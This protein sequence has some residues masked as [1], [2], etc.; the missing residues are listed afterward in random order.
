MYRTGRTTC[1]TIACINRVYAVLMLREIKYNRHLSIK[2][3]SLVM[4]YFFY[5]GPAFSQKNI[6]DNEFEF[7]DTLKT[8]NDA[9]RQISDA[10]G[11]YFTYNINLINKDRIINYTCHPKPL[12][13]IL[14]E[15]IN[16]STIHFKILDNHII[17][18][19]PKKSLPTDI[20]TE[21]VENKF[22]KLS[23]RIYDT[24]SG[25]SLPF[26]TI[27]VCNN[28]KGTISNTEGEFI[29]NLPDSYLND[30]LCVS[31]LGYHNYFF[32]INKRNKLKLDIGLKLDYVPIQEVIIRNT[33]ALQIIKE[34]IA[35]IHKNYLQK[36]AMMTTFYREAVKKRNEYLAYAE[37]IL[38]IY[39]VGYSNEF[40]NDRIKVYKSRKNVSPDFTDSISL[41]LQGGLRTSLFLDLIKNTPD[42]LSA[43]N[44]N[45]YF[46]RMTDIITYDGE[47]VYVIEFEPQKK[48]RDVF[49]KG[50]IFI[51]NESLAIR[52]AEFKIH[53]DRVR[54][55]R[56]WFV[57]K[58]RWGI[59]IKVVSASY[60]VD[61]R[62]INNKNYL[63]HV[64][65]DLRFKV[66]KRKNILYTTYDT[67]IEMGTS[68]IDT[69]NINKFRMREMVKP[70]SV[71]TE[72]KLSY[73]YE[74]WGNMNI[75]KPEL[76]IRE[77]LERIHRL[78]E[79]RNAKQK[80]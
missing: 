61:Y 37:A 11:Y 35:S 1:L 25:E 65:A 6:L 55:A 27:S 21:V 34:A 23:G 58:K 62:K 39:K 51:D 16:D 3:L 31:C 33:E 45:S 56:N 70:N 57:V 47:L 9:F 29:L 10:S 14:K 13:K 38:K 19:Q 76:P 73:D 46:Y 44:F 2:L 78:R 48:Q 4:F 49:Y 59:K 74:F 68:D 15:I 72:L 12:K 79:S 40:E 30:S 77:A 71:F 18:Y 53:P 60:K 50:R 26:A 66:K 8:L 32:K 36:P 69:I 80:Q 67:F 7:S 28:N 75:I 43:E 64:R 41:K 24:D 5:A 22:I 20:K 17:I 52:G 54:E 42:F 63:N